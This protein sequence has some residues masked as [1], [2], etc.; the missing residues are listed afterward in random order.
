MRERLKL[1]DGELSIGSQAQ[2]GTEVHATVPLIL[3]RSP[4][5]G[6]PEEPENTPSSMSAE[7]YTLVRNE[8]N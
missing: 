8:K 4:P 6:C 2:K 7:K 1:V 5:R 3:A